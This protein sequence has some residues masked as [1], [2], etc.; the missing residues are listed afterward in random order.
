[1]RFWA[2][3]VLDTHNIGLRSGRPTNLPR[4]WVVLDTSIHADSFSRLGSVLF[5]ASAFQLL[6]HVSHSSGPSS[7]LFRCCRPHF[8]VES[9][10]A[11]AKQRM[12]DV[13]AE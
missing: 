9:S 1:M 8:F 6:S 11:T 4:V 5:Q 13:A 3:K 2:Q 10:F 12:A 7:L